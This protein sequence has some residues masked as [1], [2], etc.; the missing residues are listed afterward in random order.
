MVTNNVNCNE[1]QRKESRGFTLIELLVVLAVIALL[2][3][4]SLPK[5]FQSIDIAKDRVLAENL[6]ITRDVISKFYGD[7]GRFPDSLNELVEKKYL[8]EIPIDPVTEKA[9]ITIAPQE[10]YKGNVYDVKTSASGKSHLGKE[11]AN[12]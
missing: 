1:Y 2:L 7:T 11:Y 3:T 12:F 5:Y 10:A 9:F 8:R 6:K 4:I